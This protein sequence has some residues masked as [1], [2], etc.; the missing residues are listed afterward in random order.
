MSTD[1]A[2]EQ[3]QAQ[4]SSI[5]DMVAALECDYDRLEELR[6]ELADFVCDSPL[7]NDD[8]AYKWRA[9]FPEEADELSDLEDAAG[10]CTDEDDARQR[11]YE[12]PL[13]IQ[14]RDGWRDPGATSDG[15]EE[16]EILLC[17]GGPAVRIIGEIGC[18]NEPIGPRIQYQDWF[19]AWADLG[20]LDAAQR[21][22]LQTYCETHYFGED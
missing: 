13:S 1:H 17:T 22:A 11:I 4:L 2:L 16:F 10:D 9:E 18:H 7:N 8:A 19:T 20:V 12:D 6:E 5:V 14:V 15:A 21:A 3:A